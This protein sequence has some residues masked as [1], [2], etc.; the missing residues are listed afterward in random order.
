MLYFVGNITDILQFYTAP[1]ASNEPCIKENSSFLTTIF[2]KPSHN[3]FIVYSNEK[4][5]SPGID[6]EYSVHRLCGMPGDTL[7]I[8][9]GVLFVNSKM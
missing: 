9:D 5:V 6:E 4:T 1:S 2:K 7:L 3:D 8:K